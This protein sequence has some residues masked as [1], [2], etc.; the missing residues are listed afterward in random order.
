M[1][2]HAN[3]WLPRT[4]GNSSWRGSRMKKL[5]GKLLNGE[6]QMG[7]GNSSVQLGSGSVSA[8]KRFRSRSSES[9]R[10]VLSVILGSSVDAV[11]VWAKAPR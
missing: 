2:S 11:V 3:L 8:K 6:Q 4:K 5:N 7:S 10:S 1:A 9:L